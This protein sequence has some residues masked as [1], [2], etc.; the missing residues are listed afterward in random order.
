M[1]FAFIFWEGSG[2][3]FKLLVNLQNLNENLP[4]IWVSSVIR[5]ILWM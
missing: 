5:E 2:R 4:F 3:Y 1:I